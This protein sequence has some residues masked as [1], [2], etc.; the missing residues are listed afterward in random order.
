MNA[1]EIERRR[2]VE[3]KETE[4]KVEGRASQRI[5][6][7]IVFSTSVTDRYQINRNDSMI[8]KKLGRTVF[9]KSRM[10]Q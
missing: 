8:N 6:D 3:S 5:V 7:V 1:E 2:W 10:M 4:R 9:R